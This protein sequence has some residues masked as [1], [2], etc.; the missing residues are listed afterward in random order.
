VHVHVFAI[1]QIA[2]YAVLITDNSAESLT[3]TEQ[4]ASAANGVSAAAQRD[5]GVVILASRLHGTAQLASVAE[6]I[7]KDTTLGYVQPLAAQYWP[8]RLLQVALRQ[9]QL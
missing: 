2:L 8:N 6:H 1:V 4:A 5:S 7:L 9:A 3:V